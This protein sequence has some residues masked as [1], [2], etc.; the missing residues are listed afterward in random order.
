MRLREGAA[1]GW[2]QACT[3][4]NTAQIAASRAPRDL[5]PIYNVKHS[6]VCRVSFK[7]ELTTPACPIKDEF[8]RKARDYVSSLPWVSQVRV[9]ICLHI[10]PCMPC[11]PA[12][13]MYYVDP[14]G[15]LQVF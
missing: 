2:R 9:C 8:E 12:A 3:P 1:G 14:C 15:L 11:T 7:L 10:Q 4:H 13:C 5:L 6:V